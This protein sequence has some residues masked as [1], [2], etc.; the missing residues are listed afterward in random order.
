[1]SRSIHKS[2]DTPGSPA[3]GEP[4]LLR[5]PAFLV[6]GKLRRPH[7]V[8]GE[9]MMEVITDFP[10]RLR[11]GIRVFVGED[12]KPLHIRSCRTVDRGMLVLFEEASTPEEAGEWRNALVAVQTD[13]IP[14][15]PEGEYYH[16]QILGLNVVTDTGRELGNVTEILE[17]GANDVCVVRMESD[18]EILIP[19]V[20]EFLL[21]IDLA[22]GVM[23]VHLLDEMDI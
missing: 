22:A 3:P 23:R 13:E 20:E 2:M 17:T 21:N 8:R 12:R 9:M 7:G 10:E 15:L 18:R 6:V 4:D 14:S 5:R 11:P 16:H 1:M 19:L